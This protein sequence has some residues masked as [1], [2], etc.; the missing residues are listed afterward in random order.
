[1]V[2]LIS[3]LRSQA[4]HAKHYNIDSSGLDIAA[5][6]DGDNIVKITSLFLL[7]SYGKMHA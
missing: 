4:R 7:K 3:S 6:F 1:M 5:E 2:C